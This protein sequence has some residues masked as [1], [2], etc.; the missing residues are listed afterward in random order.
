M[1]KVELKGLSFKAY[2]GYYDEERELGNHFEIDISVTS[3]FEDAAASD[4]LNKVVDYEVLYAIVK[5]EMQVSSS[6]LES[7]VVRI[8]NR[9]INELALVESVKVSLSKLNPPIKGECREAK[10]TFEKKRA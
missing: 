8:A 7:V 1:G 9:V 2:H 3:E 10:V 6:L 4:D 5:K